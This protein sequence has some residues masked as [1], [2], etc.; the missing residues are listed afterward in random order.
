[1]GHAVGNNG[2]YSAEVQEGLS[3]LRKDSSTAYNPI[4]PHTKKRILQEHRTGRHCGLPAA[5]NLIRACT[6]FQPYG[7]LLQYNTAFHGES[8]H[9]AFLDIMEETDANGQNNDV[10]DI[11]EA[12]ACRIDETER[13]ASRPKPT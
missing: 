2:F 7:A 8:R 4:F 9:A 10:S 13:K 1:M 12:P 6:L 11:L 3:C 5:P